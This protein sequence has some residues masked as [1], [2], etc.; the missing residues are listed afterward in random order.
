MPVVRTGSVGPATRP[1]ELPSPRGVPSG[2][3]PGNDIPLGQGD[4]AIFG[5]F[6]GVYLPGD[7]PIGDRDSRQ[8]VPRIRIDPVQAP[9]TVPVVLPPVDRSKIQIIE[10]EVLARPAVPAPQP[11][12]VIRSPSPPPATPKGEGT[13][14]QG[15][16]V[17]IK[18]KVKMADLS[19]LGDLATDYIRSRIMPQQQR[20][21]MASYADFGGSSSPVGIPFGEVVG[22]PGDTPGSHYLKWDKK[23]QS[24][25]THKH[26]R[27]RK[28]LLTPTDLSD[29][30]VLQTLVGKGSDSMKF[31][32]MKAVRRS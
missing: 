26:R 31:A 2:P 19:I 7:V 32:V 9:G 21:I 13:G 20:P 14:D 25:V 12:T 10:K 30:A 23:L 15:I 1:E 4:R 5:G 29:L 17:T 28:R 6:P 27:R 3:L 11:P 18:R 16:R 8:G 24:W 22:D